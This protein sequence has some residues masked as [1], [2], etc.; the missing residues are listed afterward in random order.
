MSDMPEEIY[1]EPW[2]RMYWFDSKEEADGC[3][4]TKY[5]RADIHEA[6]KKG[7]P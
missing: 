7:E 2:D 5:I 1:A 3:Y 4:S 6:L